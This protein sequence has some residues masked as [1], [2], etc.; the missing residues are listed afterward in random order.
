MILEKMKSC[1]WQLETRFKNYGLIRLLVPSFPKLVFRSPTP[2]VT[3]LGSKSFF[4]SSFINFYLKQALIFTFWVIFGKVMSVYSQKIKK[5]PSKIFFLVPFQICKF[6]LILVSSA[7]AASSA[8]ERT[9]IYIYIYIYLCQ[10][11]RNLPKN[12][13]FLEH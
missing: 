2:N 7:P 11:F 5:K 8:A 1:L 13:P 3:V 6:S 10:A 4:I 12:T 9:D